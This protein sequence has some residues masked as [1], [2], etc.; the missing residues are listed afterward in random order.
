LQFWLQIEQA[1][2][3]ASTNRIKHDGTLQLTLLHL[4]LQLLYTPPEFIHVARENINKQPLQGR[5]T[6]G[7]R[8]ALAAQRTKHQLQEDTP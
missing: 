4:H 2:I 8:R 1:A 3:R 5:A 7:L 6:G